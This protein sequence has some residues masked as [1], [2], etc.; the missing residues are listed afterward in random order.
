M[1]WQITGEREREVAGNL[2]PQ[3]QRA[4]I[5]GETARV[6]KGDR[7]RTDVPKVG[8]NIEMLQG[9]SVDIRCSEEK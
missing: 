8:R 1:F 6:R 2:C 9:L 5:A 4:L 7:T 3:A